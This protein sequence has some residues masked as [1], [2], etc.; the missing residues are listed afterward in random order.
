MN[1]Q[2]GVGRGTRGSH[3]PVL[4]RRS[5]SVDRNGS[6]FRGEP[7]V[8]GQ[9][10]GTTSRELSRLENRLA[11]VYEDK[12]DGLIDD[13]TWKKHHERYKSEIAEVKHRLD[14]HLGANLD[15]YEEGV[16]ILEIAQS[17]Y[18]QYIRQNNEEKRRLLDCVVSKCSVK[19]DEIIPE[20]RKPFDLL[21]VKKI[22]VE[23]KRRKWGKS[24]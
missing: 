10:A 1:D 14:R 17:A 3:W 4:N 12:L 19:G 20:Y 2:T 22:E 18:S 13:D 15:Y 21:A 16:R 9:S 6:P 24:A 5:V 23:K 8:H 7:P 11:A